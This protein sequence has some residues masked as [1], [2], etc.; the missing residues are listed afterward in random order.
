MNNSVITISGNLVSDAKPGLTSSNVP[1][2]KLRVA[3]TERKRSPQGS[4]EDGETT[5][6]DVVCWR[7]LSEG[8][9]TLK[10]GQRVIAFGRLRANNWTKADGT[11]VYDY[12][13]DADDVASSVFFTKKEESGLSALG[14]ESW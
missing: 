10:K 13:I 6:I 12:E 4:W 11:K 3:S 7:R 9:S 14:N 8:A 2:T 1:F 5:Y